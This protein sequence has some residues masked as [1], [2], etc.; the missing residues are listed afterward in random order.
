MCV[1]LLSVLRI[2]DKKE[3]ENQMAAELCKATAGAKE[4]LPVIGRE[5]LSKKKDAML[6]GV[7]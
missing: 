3:K 1:E 4:F 6:F 7:G 5:G 2:W